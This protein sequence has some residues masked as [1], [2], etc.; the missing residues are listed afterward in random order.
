MLWWPY[1]HTRNYTHHKEV[2]APGLLHHID[3]K[4]YDANEE[5]AAEDEE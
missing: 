5:R 1:T 4:N 3:D 2:V